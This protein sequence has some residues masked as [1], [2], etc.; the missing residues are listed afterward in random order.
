MAWLKIQRTTNSGARSNSTNP[1]PAVSRVTS[2]LP[3]NFSM[4]NDFIGGVSRDTA[5]DRMTHLGDSSPRNGLVFRKDQPCTDDGTF[6]KS[7]QA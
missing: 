2:L 5:P 7:H 4:R 6:E 1:H 3:S